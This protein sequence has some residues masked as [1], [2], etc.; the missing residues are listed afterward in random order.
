M[1]QG[2]SAGTVATLTL[3]DQ[4]MSSASNALL[5]VSLAQ[6][7]SADR[8]GLVGLLVA[9]VMVCLGFN[10]GALGTPLLLTSNLS[11]REILAE[12]G[13][14]VSWA[15]TTGAIAGSLL[16]IIGIA[17]SE[18]GLTYAFA[19]SLP[20]VLTQD[21]LRITVIALGRPGIALVA[22]SLWTAVLVAI[23]FANIAGA[24][25]TTFTTVL[26]WGCSGSLSGL[27]IAFW[28]NIRPRAYRI[29]SWWRTYYSSR[30][31]FGGLPAAGQMSALTVSFIAFET[32]GSVAAAGVRGSLTLFGPITVLISALPMIFVPHSARKRSTSV[33]QWRMLLS[34]SVATSSLAIV[35]TLFICALPESLGNSVLGQS[36]GPTRELVPFI[37]VECAA[38]AWRTS[39]YT[40][41][42][43]QGSSHQVFQLSASHLVLQAVATT[44]AGLW[45]H[46]NLA[47]GIAI[48]VS[49][50]AV[51]MAGV[52]AAQVWL[53]RHATPQPLDQ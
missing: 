14:A 4:V 20:L 50:V 33:G 26:V 11:K 30:L 2:K 34:T 37:G 39:V 1:N 22:D 5:A 31:R 17:I 44:L 15:L 8:F 19:M 21:V 3:A 41:F 25:F 12:A 40:F 46:S 28:V 42:Q 53:R 6:T 7:S 35:A 23:V 43:S 32:V 49:G 24:H 18:P 9:V 29:F 38:A 45:F 48:V 52:L 16:V 36:W 13:Y 10:R 27:L 51:A 47:I